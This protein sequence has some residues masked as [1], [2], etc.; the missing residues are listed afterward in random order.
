MVVRALQSGWTGRNVPPMSSEP[1]SSSRSRRTFFKTAGAIA[2]G[3]AATTMACT[4][5]ETS[6]TSRTTGFDRALLDPLAEAVLP[7]DAGDHRAIATAFVTWV[8][9]YDPVAE[10]MHGYGY[11]DIRYLPA[12]PAP[13]WR[14]Q[15][16]AL[17]TLAQKM[18][19]RGFAQLDR[20][21]RQGIVAA[22][23]GGERGDRLPAPLQARHV[24]VAL[25]AHWASGPQAWN[26]ALG[27]EVSPGA[28][29]PLDGATR[30]PLPVAPGGRAS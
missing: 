17:D 4:T 13:A 8:D 25:L 24:A 21:T 6:T 3:V 10:E 15:L 5:A 12:D 7:A 23:L 18:H 20:A 2:S 16:A 26:L 30:M 1:T 29:R 22:A 9:G 19:R 14:A 28:C 27:A 11:S